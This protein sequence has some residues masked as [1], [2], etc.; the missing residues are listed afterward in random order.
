MILADWN[1]GGDKMS[2][3]QQNPCQQNSWFSSPGCKWVPLVTPA[4]KDDCAEVD[5]TLLQ[6]RM[7]KVFIVAIACLA[8]IPPLM[9]LGLP[10]A[11]FVLLGF[12][13][14]QFGVISKLEPWIAAKACEVKAVSEYLTKECP[15][16]AATRLI[17][18]KP[19]L[20]RKLVQQ[21]ARRDLEKQNIM[22]SRLLEYASVVHFDVFKT[23]VDAGADLKAKTKYNLESMFRRTVR[24][25][26]TRY[27][28]YIL[29]NQKVRACDFIQEEHTQ[30]YTAAQT[31]Q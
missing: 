29:Q 20:A 2:A 17:R 4:V 13:I 5:N 23:L 12:S 31:A 10:T 3:V 16:L 22:G 30:R 24:G 7:L 11:A 6:E 8:L 25:E 19:R 9:V 14:V 15:S 28:A 27:L 21:G 18:N 1:H 26:D